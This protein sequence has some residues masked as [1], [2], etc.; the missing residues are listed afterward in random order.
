M[1]F[2]ELISHTLL[3][4]YSASSIRVVSEMATAAFLPAARQLRCLS[5]TS[6]K[7]HSIQGPAVRALLRL[8]GI[9]QTAIKAS[10]PKHNVIKTD[11]LKY[12]HAGNLRP[13]MPYHI[14]PI[15]GYP[16]PAS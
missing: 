3:C 12:I 11:V 16:S 10:G 15:H 9:N 2:S 13:V 4:S 14:T 8:Y 6:G 7:I 5:T 1:S